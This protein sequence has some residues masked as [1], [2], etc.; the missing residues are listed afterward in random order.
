MSV[1]FK[2]DPNYHTGHLFLECVKSRPSA[3]FQ[4][5]AATGAEETNASVLRRSV[6]LAQCF[7][8][9]GLKPG[10]VL[11]LGGRNHLDLHI[12]YYAALMNGLPIAGVD[13]LFK[14][15]EIKTHFTLSRP[16]VAF[17]QKENLEDYKRAADELE[18]DTLIFTFDGENSMKELIEKYAGDD[19]V[20]GFEPA[21]FD[22]DKVYVWLVSTSGTT[23]GIK[24]A[25]LKHKVLM[26]KLQIFLLALFRSDSME[27][28]KMGLNLSPVQW[29]TAFFNAVGMPL[30]HQT[31]LQTSAKPTTE[32]VIDIINKYK[33]VTVFVGPSLLTSILKHEKKCDFTCFDR[34]LSGGGRVHKDILIE[35]RK[36]TRNP[37]CFFEIYGQTEN[38]GPILVPNPLGPLG[39]CGKCM[40]QGSIKLVDPE[41]GKEI[42]APNTPGELWSKTLCFSEYYNNPQETA[43]AFTEDGF[44]KTGDVL[45]KDEDQNYFYVERLKMLIK[46]R[47]YHVAPA[48]L[49]ELIRTLPG[50][51]DVSVTSVQHVEDGEWPVACVVRRY[52]AQ[53]TAQEIEDLIAD[54]LSDSKK[55]RGGVIFMDELPLTST[56]KVAR[57]ILHKIVRDL[58]QNK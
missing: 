40:V 11:A 2:N 12:P 36:L 18:L 44:Y 55:L 9:L 20:D 42:T 27:D 21:I 47:S 4:I 16:K 15:E 56:G 38:L 43:E 19:S 54:K 29:V 22:L 17:C 57:A 32:H 24:L 1:L 10:D 5:D 51:H 39:N 52:G 49:E 41:T 7:R 45:Y 48:E 50:V 46:Y 26:E 58:L 34:L 3:I 33:P 30:N 37:A 25:A 23:G 13:P 31:K 28:N 14:F 53:V 35:L 8:S 6:L